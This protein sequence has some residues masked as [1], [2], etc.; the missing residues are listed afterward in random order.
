MKKFFRNILNATKEFRILI[1]FAGI[2]LFAY[3][4]LSFSLKKLS[5]RIDNLEEA[6]SDL[7]PKETEEE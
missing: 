7:L 3:L 5:K 6:Y 4:P 1:D 2:Y